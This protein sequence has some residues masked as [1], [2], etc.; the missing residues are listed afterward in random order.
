MI[1]F[2]DTLYTQLGTT[3]NTAL[4]LIYILHSSPLPTHKGLQPSLVVFWK[5]VYESLTVT[6]NHT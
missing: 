4:T 6:S 2:I 1:E 5:R 3:G